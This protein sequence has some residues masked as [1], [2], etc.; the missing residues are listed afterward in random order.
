MCTSVCFGGDDL[1][2]LYI[3]SGSEGTGSDRG[4]AVHRIRVP[5][6]GLPVAPARVKLP[7]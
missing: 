5:V 2:D 6:A 1:Q 4:G 7:G 3:V